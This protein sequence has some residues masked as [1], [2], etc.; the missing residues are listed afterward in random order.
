MTEN[1][2]KDIIDIN[3]VDGVFIASNR[4]QVIEK[5][6]IKLDDSVLEGVAIHVLRIISAYHVKKR[7][8]KEVEIIWNNYRII[9]RNSNEFV[10]ISFCNS[11]KELSLLRI[12]LN[13]VLTHLLED[14]KFKKQIE[15][16][17][18]QKTVVL[19]KGNLDPMEINLISKLQ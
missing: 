7:I 4:G 13:V 3:G 18:T 2:L 15:Q 12:T 1:W 11:E 17:A 10:I 16:H 19:R 8:I 6:G 14:K 9:A 5:V